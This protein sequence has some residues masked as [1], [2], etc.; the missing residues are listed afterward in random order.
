MW[1]IERTATYLRYSTM[2]PVDVNPLRWRAM[3]RQIVSLY[4]I[5]WI[6]PF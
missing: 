5:G 2:R 3:I 1:T 6:A 4:G